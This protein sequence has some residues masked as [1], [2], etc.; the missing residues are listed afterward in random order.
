M[1][2]VIFTEFLDLVE[3]QFGL[4][5][6]DQ[7]LDECEDEGIY[8]SV[9]TYDHRDLVKLIVALSKKTEISAEDLQQVYGKS[10]FSK[11]HS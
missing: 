6:L 1:K 9:G 5:T 3:Q 2:G 10:I 8:T 11:L 4:S 7:I